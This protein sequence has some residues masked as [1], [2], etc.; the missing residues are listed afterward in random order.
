MTQLK[1]PLGVNKGPHMPHMPQVEAGRHT[2]D[3]LL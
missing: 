2:V 3:H 1:G